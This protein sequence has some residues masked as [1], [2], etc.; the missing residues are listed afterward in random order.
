MDSNRPGGISLGSDVEEH[1][2]I[3]ELHHRRHDSNM[4]NDSYVSSDGD[5]SIRK[6]KG[7]AFGFDDA[8]VE[9][10]EYEPQQDLSAEDQESAV[11]PQ[12]RKRFRFRGGNRVG[13]TSDLPPE[14]PRTMK[15]RF[16][17]GLFGENKTTGQA[18]MPDG[19]PVNLKALFIEDA[20]A[21]VRAVKTADYRVVARAALQRTWWSKSNLIFPTHG[22]H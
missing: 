16:M 19:T 13:S 3:G 6:G 11:P 17:R 1:L 22:S 2:A 18:L 5:A 8:L 21:I 7:K 20:K 15:E 14:P 9:E 12:R 10:D 4:T